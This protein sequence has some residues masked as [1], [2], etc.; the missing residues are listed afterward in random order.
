MCCCTEKTEPNR[1]SLCGQIRMHTQQSAEDSVGMEEERL[2][3]RVLLSSPKPL[4][5][6]T[7]Q[8]C[9]RGLYSALN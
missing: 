8:C 6:Y 4:D 1:K 9:T 5:Q 2:L 3:S 7:A